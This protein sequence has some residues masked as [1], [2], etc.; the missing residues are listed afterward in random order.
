MNLLVTSTLTSLLVFFM[1]QAKA[2]VPNIHDRI[3][4]TELLLMSEPNRIQIAKERA[5]ELYPEF[6]K[7]AFASERNIQTRW[8]ALLTAVQIYPN[9]AGADIQRALKH[10]D[11]FMRNAGL[12]SLKIINPK[13][14][15]KAAL[16][17]LNDKALVVR[18]AAVNVLSNSTT[19]ETRTALWNEL[20]ASHNFWKGQSLWI[21]QEILEKL[22]ANPE[23]Q[24]YHAFSEMLK[25]SDQNLPA[26]AISALEKITHKTLGRSSAAL[27]EKKKL[28]LHY[29][30]EHALF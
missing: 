2:A 29:T 7:I 4:P 9:G 21:R 23:K 22:S 1:L 14:A 17:L 6:I 10:Q 11:W 25:D 28:W 20:K 19:P 15:E 16:E 27:A 3:T 5:Q 8:S 13:S 12:L 24:D 26:T 18:S 30:K